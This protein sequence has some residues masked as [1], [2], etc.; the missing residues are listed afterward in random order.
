MR[1]SP[2]SFWRLCRWPRSP[3]R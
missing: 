3:G 1:I 2:S